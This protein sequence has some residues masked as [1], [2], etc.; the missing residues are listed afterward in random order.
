MR[1]LLT[2]SLLLTVTVVCLLF[3]RPL[4]YSAMPQYGVSVK[5]QSE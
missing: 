4:F 3:L 1:P 2:F 5:Q